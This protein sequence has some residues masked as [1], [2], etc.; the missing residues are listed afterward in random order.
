MKKP[1]KPLL[2][3]LCGV[4]AAAVIGALALFLG[5]PEAASPVVSAGLQHLADDAYL[6]ASAVAGQDV[7]FTAEWF[8]GALAG[9]AVTAVTV[10]R[11]PAATEGTLKL[12][13]GSV[14]TGQ[15]IP[16]ESLSFLRFIPNDGVKNSSFSFVPSTRSGNAGYALSCRLLVLDNVNCCPQNTKTA[17]A[18]STHEGLTLRGT[19]TARDPEGDT[20]HFEIFTYPENGTL[21]LNAATGAF[22]YTPMAGFSGKDSFSW[23]VQ[24]AA[25]AY[26]P[27]T[28]VSVTVRESTGYTFADMEGHAAHTHALRVSEEGLLGGERMGGKH[29]FHPHKALN[30]AAFVAILLEAAGIQAPPADSTGYTDDAEIPAGMKGAIK[31]AREQGWLGEDTAFRPN[32][33]ITRAEAARIAAAALGLSAPGY[34][35]A[36][37]DHTAIP[38]DVADAL[39]AIYEGGYI[40][41][42]ADG[43]LSPGGVL[44]R[45]DAAKFFARVLDGRG[46]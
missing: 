44:S 6:A 41:T 18:V 4:V 36:V 46:V 24:D 38:V 3:A 8:D 7:S 45:G 19:L 27:P 43:T 31:Y 40:S 29:Y 34:H 9:E 10:T 14:Q 16:R 28:E 11:L 37:E 30:R 42:L 12:G 25:G 32:E 22:T 17:T 13:H 20:L 26:A 21:T 23:R 35:E 15:I 5:N 33:A 39:Y 2:F 1:K